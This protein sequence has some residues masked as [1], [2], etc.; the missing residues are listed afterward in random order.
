MTTDRP[1]DAPPAGATRPAKTLS[2]SLVAGVVLAGA[3][4]LGGLIAT[5]YAAEV[6]CPDGWTPGPDRATPLGRSVMT[7]ATAHEDLHGARLHLVWTSTGALDD[8][9]LEALGRAAGLGTALRPEPTREDGIE[10]AH[11]TVEREGDKLKSDVYFLSAGQRYGLL[12]I[13]YGPAAQFVEEPQ[14]VPWLETIEGGAP[15]GA[16]VTP[17]LSARCPE[18]FTALPS[19]AAGMLL[20]CMR[21]VGTAAF[22]VIQLTQGEGGFGSERDR[23]TLA[24]DVTRRVAGARTNARVIEDPRPFTQ[25]RNLDA[26]RARIETD[27]RLTLST[28]V[29]WARTPSSG[30][31]VALYVGPDVSAG[32]AALRAFVRPVRA[33]R[34]P[35][36][37]LWGL[38]FVVFSAAVAVGLVRSRRPGG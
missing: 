18:G 26:L 30:N 12:T 25:A 33:S 7:C 21:G 1:S 28:R 13:V 32:E 19:G 14:V 11:A 8:A 16:P 27:E 29:A 4:A 3:V 20:R 15:W 23:E 24:R 22:T 5:G 9:A 10:G 37:A 34:V 31:V 6:S 36:M 35:G 38:A 17:T 2:L